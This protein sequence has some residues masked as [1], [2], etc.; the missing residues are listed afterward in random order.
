MTR[1]EDAIRNLIY[2]GTDDPFGGR[3]GAG[4]YAIGDGSKAVAEAFIKDMIDAVVDARLP[5]RCPICH[6]P[7]DDAE[8]GVHKEGASA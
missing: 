4:R 1:L 8:M 7:L 3:A 6:R 2:V 5:E